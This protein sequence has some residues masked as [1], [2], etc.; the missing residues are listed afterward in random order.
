MQKNYAFTFNRYR[1]NVKIV[2]FHTFFNMVQYSK[3]YYSMKFEAQMNRFSNKFRFNVCKDGTPACS[4]Q[5]I[6]VLLEHHFGTTALYS[7]LDGG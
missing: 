1:I 3:C 4:W 7:V 2:T 6:G 5:N